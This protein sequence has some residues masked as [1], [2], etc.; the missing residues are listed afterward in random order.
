MMSCL[1]L[2]SIQKNSLGFEQPKRMRVWIA[3]S[4][5]KVLAPFL[6]TMV[7]QSLTTPGSSPPFTYPFHVMDFVNPKVRLPCIL[8]SSTTANC[9]TSSRLLVPNLNRR[10]SIHFHSRHTGNTLLNCQR[11]CIRRAI[12]LTPGTINSLI[13]RTLDGMTLMQTL[14]SKLSSS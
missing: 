10:V 13:L 12:L 1:L 2:I 11:G 7:H 9:L 4:F 8:S 3:T 14:T 5:N 6:T